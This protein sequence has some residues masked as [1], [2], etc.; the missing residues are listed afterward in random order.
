M[1]NT[2]SLLVGALVL[3]GAVFVSTPA[4]A[5]YTGA[6][7]AQ[8]NNGTSALLSVMIQNN[9]NQQ[10][11]QNQVNR[12]MMNNESLLGTGRGGQ[13]LTRGQRLIKSGRATVAFSPRAFPI[14]TYMKG[15]WSGKGD[16]ALRKRNYTEWL[17]QSALWRAEVAARGAKSNDY[18]QLEALAFVMCAEA[19]NGG[20]I[21]NEGWKRKVAS[22][23]PLYLKSAGF[24]GLSNL[25]KQERIEGSMVSASYALYLRQTG[26]TAQARKVASTYL[27]DNWDTDHKGVPDDQDAVATVARFVT[28]P[29]KRPTIRPVAA[30]NKPLTAP[31]STST[32]API[33]SV[34]FQKA[35]QLTSFRREA[36]LASHDLMM[37]AGAGTADEATLAQAR[38]VFEKL[39]E[40]S[41]AGLAKN[42]KANLPLDNVAR[43]MASSLIFT[44]ALALTTPGKKVG[45]GVPTQTWEQTE[46][47]RRQMALALASDPGFARISDHQK[48]E[49]FEIYLLQP[50]FAEVIYLSGLQQNNIALQNKAR[51]MARQGFKSLVGF[52]PSRA[53]FTDDGLTRSDAP[54]N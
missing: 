47:L 36:G 26:N 3:S 4:R 20:H 25:Q 34:S 7:G 39:I 42:T 49:A 50:A 6:L 17:A 16:A 23:R 41:R 21:S 52:E 38:S 22:M 12:Q 9:M 18:V 33:A 1:K 8:F 14:G 46:A 48:Q 40:Q 44:H 19:F 37:Q 2:R 11:L 29:P 43:A 51:E 35:A 13:G 30:T 5:Q 32:S 27:S 54:A 15:V 31:A 10:M 24:Q 45:E 28:A 53:R